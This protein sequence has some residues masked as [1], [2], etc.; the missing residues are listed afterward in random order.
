MR[1]SHVWDIRDER[2]THIQAMFRAQIRFFELARDRLHIS[3]RGNVK[4]TQQ[5]MTRVAAYTMELCTSCIKNRA[6]YQCL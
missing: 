4:R 3:W 2:L 5:R 6:Y 1:G